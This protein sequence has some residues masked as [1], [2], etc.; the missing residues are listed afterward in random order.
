MT[1]TR[2]GKKRQESSSSSATSSKQQPKWGQR[3][4]RYCTEEKASEGI[5]KHS[6][7]AAWYSVLPDLKQNAA[8]YPYSW[9]IGTTINGQPQ[10]IDA[11]TGLTRNFSGD[12]EILNLPGAMHLWL[13]PSLGSSNSRDSALNLAVIQ[14]YTI[15]RK[16]NSGG[17]NYDPVDLFIYIAA[18][19]SVF[20]YIN[21]L[22]RLYGVCGLY[23]QKNRYLPRYL[24]EGMGVDYDSISSN[25]A[26][27]RYRLNL[28]INKAS[29]FAVP[30]DIHYFKRQAFNFSGLYTEGESIKDQLYLQN[31][32]R[33]FRFALDADGAGQLDCVVTPMY[34]HFLANPTPLATIDDLFEFADSLIQPLLVN[35]DFGIMNGDVL[36]AYGQS[37]ILTLKQIDENYVTVPEFNLKVLEQFKNARP[38]SYLGR[39]S[40][41]DGNGNDPYV[42]YVHQSPDKGYLMTN[43]HFRLPIAPST[44]LASMIQAAEYGGMISA[45]VMST[46]SA[47]PDTDI[48]VENTRLMPVVQ[49]LKIEA[50]TT[51]NTGYYDFDLVAG[52]DI[53]VYVNMTTLANGTL[54]NQIYH[55]A[56]PMSD[57]MGFTYNASSAMNMLTK[58]SHFEFR[59]VQYLAARASNGGIQT[60][61]NWNVDNYT[62][63]HGQDL[64]RL[65][66]MCLMSLLH[67]DQIAK[68]S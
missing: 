48:T 3:S 23:A 20:G 42:G 59:P 61:L 50:N 16:M 19:S 41:T 28:F 22:Q 15:V 33:M 43:S 64:V 35:E 30:A 9:P 54:D 37:G 17:A 67:V 51:T 14:L 8:S 58:A 31:P 60:R 44:S 4:A 47:D 21:F 2:T 68:L 13:I 38:C 27:F 11:A 53:V 10:F 29:S 12:Q 18:M 1:K 34:S 32:A 62:V 7:D 24:V 26:D 52:A 25:L 46:H 57:D 40:T 65:H 5:K 49:N 66:E 6:N 55:G 36:K 56:L 63:L 39:R 45:I